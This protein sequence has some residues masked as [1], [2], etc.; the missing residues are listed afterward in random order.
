[1]VERHHLSVITLFCDEPFGAGAEVRLQGNAARHARVRRAARGDGVRLLDGKGRI[2]TGLVVEIA[3]SALVVTVDAL[4]EVPRPAPLDVIVPVADR[5]RMLMAAEKCTELQVTSWRPVYFVRS[6][7]VTPR[8]EGPRFRE[9]VRA[10]MQSALEQSG[11]AWLP[12]V[13]DE[14]EASDA[15]GSL[16]PDYHRLLLTREGKPLAGLVTSGPV[17]FAVGPEGGLER[18]EIVAAEESG[19]VSAS[20]GVSTLRFE[21]AVVAGAAVIR[22]TQLTPGGY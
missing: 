9:K 4:T 5:D 12:D 16:S 1:M 2:A 7:S 11:G 3:K 13:N 6:R 19:W 20:L 18:S 21:T 17:A 10:R 15:W 8:G 14:M 22:A